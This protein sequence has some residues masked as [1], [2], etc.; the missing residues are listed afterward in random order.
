MYIITHK[1]YANAAIRAVN[2]LLG[3]L[4]VGAV[5]NAVGDLT[6]LTVGDLIIQFQQIIGSVVV[7]DLTY[8]NPQFA[9]ALFQLQNS[10]ADSTAFI[11]ILVLAQ[12]QQYQDFINTITQVRV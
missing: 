1:R 8:P 11:S 4:Q 10:T 5:S 3:F 9:N 7:Q 12:T 2:K 6:S